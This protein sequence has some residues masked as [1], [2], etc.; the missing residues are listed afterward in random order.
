MRTRW[1][2]LAG[3][4]A[5]ILVAIYLHSAFLDYVAALAPESDEAV[6]IR[7]Y[8]TPAFFAKNVVILGSL[9]TYFLF[10]MRLS[11]RGRSRRGRANAR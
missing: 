4:G 10:E 6:A 9:L 11:R 3:C 2:W 7:N 8:V 5:S 1:K